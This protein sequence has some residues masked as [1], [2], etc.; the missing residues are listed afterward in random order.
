MDKMPQLWKSAIFQ[1]TAGKITS[2]C[3]TNSVKKIGN[4]AFTALTATHFNGRERTKLGELNVP[5]GRRLGHGQPLAG[6][7]PTSLLLPLGSQGEEVGPGYLFLRFLLP[8]AS[9]AAP[10]IL[11][12]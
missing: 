10:R 11:I 1:G 6:P 12:G 4:D 9:L 5:L 2:N 8:A 7:G 3:N